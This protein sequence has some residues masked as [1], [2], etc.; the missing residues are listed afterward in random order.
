MASLDNNLNNHPGNRSM[1]HVATDWRRFR[2]IWAINERRHQNENNNNNNDSVE[3]KHRTEKKGKVRF[4]FWHI[5]G[6]LAAHSPWTLW[7][8]IYD[9]FLANAYPHTFAFMIRTLCFGSVVVVDCG[10]PR[11]GCALWM[12]ML[13]RFLLPFTQVDCYSLC[14]ARLTCIQY[15]LRY[16]RRRCSCIIITR[17]PSHVFRAIEHNRTFV[18]SQSKRRTCNVCRCDDDKSDLLSIVLSQ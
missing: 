13:V 6:C 5:V 14:V 1:C 15:Q 8:A 2:E 10:A 3:R 11:M 18:W 17:R 7:R 12:Y 16:N 4:Y 9:G